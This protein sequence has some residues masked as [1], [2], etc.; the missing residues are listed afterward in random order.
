MWMKQ[1][2]CKAVP[3]PEHS[4]S[5]AVSERRIRKT[6]FRSPDGGRIKGV[7]GR[8]KHQLEKLYLSERDIWAII[9]SIKFY[10]IS[11]EGV[12]ANVR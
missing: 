10:K 5:H 3:D 2:A 4:D 6:P 9:S 8:V 11:I 1:R 7:G 12:L